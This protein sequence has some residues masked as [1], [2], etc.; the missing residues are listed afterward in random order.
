MISCTPGR[1]R[2]FLVDEDFGSEVKSIVCARKEAQQR[3]KK[4][5]EACSPTHNFFWNWRRRRLDARGSRR[6]R[7]H[8][9]R[10]G[11]NTTRLRS[12]KKRQCG[13]H[14]ESCS[15][16]DNGLRWFR[17]RRRWLCNRLLRRRGRR[18]IHVQRLNTIFNK[19][20][21]HHDVRGTGHGQLLQQ[22]LFCRLKRIVVQLTNI[23]LT[24]RQL[25]HTS[26]NTAPPAL[27]SRECP[28]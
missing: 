11:S 13:T 4:T 16:L 1:V 28:P 19:T 22:H 26:N 15:G 7:N 25:R 10:L 27:S 24:G 8:G 5:E 9:W 14:F 23:V 21:T 20:T 6:H 3:Q 2:T 17:W 12:G 18:L